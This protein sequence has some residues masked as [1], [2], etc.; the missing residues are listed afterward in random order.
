MEK[1]NAQQ[2]TPLAARTDAFE[3]YTHTPGVQSLNVVL[4]SEGL[5]L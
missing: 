3:N 1:E 2:E 5:M 4:F